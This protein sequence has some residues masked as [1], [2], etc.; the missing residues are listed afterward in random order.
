M[1]FHPLHTHILPPKRFNNPFYYEP[2]PLCLLAIEEL[3]QQLP[4]HPKDGKM[5]GVLVV[6]KEGELGYLA[7]YSGQIEDEQIHRDASA[8][9]YFVPAVFDYLQPDGYFKT[10][11]AE[12]SEINHTIA[13]LEQA[14]EYKQAQAD[15]ARLQSEAETA[16]AE[17]QLAMKQ[18]KAIREAKRK[19]GNLSDEEQAKMI[20]ESQFLKAEV[21]RTKVQYKSQLEESLKKV[22]NFKMEIFHLKQKRK[23]KS[24]ALQNWLFSQFEF[25]NGKG[26][27]RKLINL[28]PYDLSPRS[29]L[30]GEGLLDAMQL[31]SQATEASADNKASKIIL[32]ESLADSNQ[33]ISQAT[34]ASTDNKASKIILQESLAD[35][36]QLI[37][38]A[39]EASADN[40]VN[41]I[42]LQKSLTDSSQLISRATEASADNKANKIILQESVAGFSQLISRATDASADNKVSK[43]ILPESLADSSQLI[44]Q[45][46]EASTDNKANKIILQESLAGSSQLISRATEASTD[47]KASK[48][49]LQES[50]AENRNPQET[51]NQQQRI[52][53]ESEALSLKGRAGR[54]VPPS[55]SGECCEPKLLQYAFLHHLKPL[56]MAMFWWGPSPKTE[57]RR[58][59][60]FY[61]ACNGKCKPILNWMLQGIEVEDNPL[62]KNAS[63]ELTILYDDKDLVVVNKPAGM[64]SVPG[65]SSRES[66]LSILK[67]KYPE[68]TG[69]MIVHRLDM[70]TSGL[71]VVAKNLETYIHLQKQFADHSIVKHYRSIIHPSVDSKASLLK[72]GETGTLSLPLAPDIMD[73]PRQKVDYEYGKKAITEYKVLEKR[74]NGEIVLQ[75]SPLTGRTHQ[76]RVHC[77]HPEG[78]NSPI[79]GDELYGIKADRLYL[80]AEYLE[81]THPRTGERIHFEQK[82]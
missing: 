72:E 29:P 16:I 35:S 52:S 49:I 26:E 61:P 37:S 65:K 8:E 36:S 71:L 15:Y 73:R 59:K 50:L 3:Q 69:P 27:K 44:F 17:K 62:E 47:N 56:C 79:K 11:E 25:L 12:I 39:T 77:A 66:V 55:G 67:A 64:L 28:E 20:R 43:I 54:E 13:R 68:A 18:A 9:Q 40:R 21:H 60:H 34:E 23:L 10:H 41:Q 46:A 30:Q 33:L 2:H 1:I 4:S 7:A 19:E 74:K 22:E 38:R 48:I 76:L 53:S 32:Q 58:H 5:Y 14:Q 63:Q 24:D 70:A 80:H 75:L 81:F 57:I 31:I 45:A 82:P 42:I 78:F 6:V 51:E